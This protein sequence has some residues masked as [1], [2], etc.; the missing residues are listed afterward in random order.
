MEFVGAV[1]EANQ[2]ALVRRL[3]VD[4]K[5]RQV[6]SKRELEPLDLQPI[7]DRTVRMQDIF[8]YVKHE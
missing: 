2:L 7:Y 4:N 8:S 5:M 3:L 6:T 1:S